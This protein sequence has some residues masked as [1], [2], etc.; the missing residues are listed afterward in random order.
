MCNRRLRS[1]IEELRV[2]RFLG[3]GKFPRDVDKIILIATIAGAL[4]IGFAAAASLG[5][6][7]VPLVRLVLLGVLGLLFTQIRKGAP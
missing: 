4:L 6:V 7:I 2:Q 5:G 3:G 1:L